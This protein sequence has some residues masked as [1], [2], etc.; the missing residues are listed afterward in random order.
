MGISVSKTN[1]DPKG[2]DKDDYQVDAISGS[3]ITGDGVTDMIFER[4]N[5][6]MVFFNNL[7]NES[8]IKK[9]S[10]KVENQ[11]NNY[12]STTIYVSLREFDKGYVPRKFMN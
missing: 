6:Y 11:K 8:D 2:Q 5:H 9:I 4:L 1:N 7:K 10:Y 12:L 3:T